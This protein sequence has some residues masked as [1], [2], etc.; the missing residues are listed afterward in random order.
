MGIKIIAK[1]GIT[2]ACYLFHSAFLNDGLSILCDFYAL[3]NV[4]VLSG[5][6]SVV[7]IESKMNKV[8]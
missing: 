2:K 3:V 1:Y 4:E 8:L 5:S 6:T 7:A